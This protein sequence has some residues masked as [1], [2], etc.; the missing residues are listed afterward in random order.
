M[1]AVAADVVF[2]VEF[3][4]NGVEV[5]V[6]GNRLVEGRVEDG[7]VGNARQELLCDVEADDVRRDVKRIERIDAFD[8]LDDVMIDEAGLGELFAAVHD[9]VS[10]GL[11]LVEGFERAVQKEVKDAFEADFMRRENFV[12]DLDFLAVSRLVFENANFFADAFD[13]AFGQNIAGR[14]VEE[15]IFHGRRAAVD[16]E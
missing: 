6:L 1:S 7:N 16:D 14:H 2:R 4:G 3:V 12:R 11:D 15:L 9:A 13:V 10:D 5:G 8:L